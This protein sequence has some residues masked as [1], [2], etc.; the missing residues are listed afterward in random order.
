MPPINTPS[1]KKDAMQVHI[2]ATLDDRLR[3]QLERVADID[4]FASTLLQEALEED[5]NFEQLAML[6]A[7]KGM[8]IADEIQYTLQDAKELY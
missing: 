3:P 6:E 1:Q 5:T 7:Q 4:D 2:T 8:D